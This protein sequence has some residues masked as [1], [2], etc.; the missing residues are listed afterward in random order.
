VND[1]TADIALGLQLRGGSI[2]FVQDKNAPP[3]R[4]G[5]LQAGLRSIGMEAL[6]EN[7][8]ASSNK[9]DVTL[10]IGEK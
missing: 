8:E 2:L 3:P 10:F 4:A 9:D 5:V 6:G 7:G 1:R